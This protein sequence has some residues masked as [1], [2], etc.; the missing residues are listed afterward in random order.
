MKRARPPT[1]AD[2]KAVTLLA[3]MKAR[4]LGYIWCPN[5]FHGAVTAD[6]VRAL[7]DYGVVQNE[8]ATEGQGYEG[9]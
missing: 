2:A 1:D 5:P 3:L 9:D 8:V 6:G 4:Q 7:A